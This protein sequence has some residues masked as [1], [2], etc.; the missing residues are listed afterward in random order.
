VTFA[1]PLVADAVALL[2]AHAYMAKADAKNMF[3]SFPTAVA[4]QHLLGFR[5][6]G[7]VYVAVRAQFGGKLYPLIANA[8]MGELSAI[9]W[10][11]GI[12]NVIYTDDPFTT[13]TGGT[14]PPG[15]ER[16]DGR[17]R[18]A[19]ELLSGAGIVINPSKDVGPAQVLPFLGVVVDV[20]RRRLYL[21]AEK[22]RYYLLVVQELQRA[23]APSKKELEHAIG[24]LNWAASVMTAGRVRI[25][26]IR[27]CLKR[28]WGGARACLTTGAREDFGLVGNPAAG[29]PSCT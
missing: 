25:P 11:E 18:R 28:Q 17:F 3:W 1:Y 10:W 14:A 20:P 19:K 27:A 16:C 15:P 23:K 5:L 26:R 29:G 6:D 2:L 24:L 7:R 22:L 21:P 13:G 4:E 8:L 9:L 12:P